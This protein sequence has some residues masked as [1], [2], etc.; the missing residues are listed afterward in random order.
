MP[1]QLPDANHDYVQI[2][3]PSFNLQRKIGGAAGK[4]LSAFAVQKAHQALLLVMP[5]LSEEVERLMKE[6]Q[7]SVRSRNSNARDVIWNNA[8]EIRGLA[9]TAGK[10]S[11]G[12]AAD[13]MC[14][15]LNGSDSNFLADPTVL[16]TIATVAI[17]AVKDG[18]DDDPMIKMLLTDCAQAV[19]VQRKREGRAASN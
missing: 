10:R 1:P 15:Y 17:Q 8:H 16:S 6:L 14:R 4:V 9:G 13:I 7:D 18:A 3:P 11:L 19:V 2:S 12:L 5:P